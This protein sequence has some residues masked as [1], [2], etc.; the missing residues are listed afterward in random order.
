MADASHRHP[1][2]EAGVGLT[3]LMVAAARAIETDRHD[4]LA[5]DVYAEHFVHAAQA[6]A[7]WPVRS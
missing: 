5:R 7:G 4:A 6:S 1:G 2:V 3:A